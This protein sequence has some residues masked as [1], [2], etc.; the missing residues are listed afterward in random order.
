MD[1]SLFPIGDVKFA[2]P[3]TEES[4]YNFPVIYKD[5]EQYYRDNYSGFPEEFYPILALRASGMKWQTY[6][7]LLRQE[8]K[9]EEKIQRKKSKQIPVTIRRCK[10]GEK[11]TI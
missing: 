11:F 6:K 7:K 8:R 3:Y 5:T 1:L 4:I 10:E 2:D 9:L